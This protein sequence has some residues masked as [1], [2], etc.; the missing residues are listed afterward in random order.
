MAEGKPR[1]HLDESV[2]PALARALRRHGIDVTTT[3]EVG[4]RTAADAEQ[5]AF[6]H[7]TGR[8]LITHDTDFLRS[9]KQETAHPGIVF[10]RHG[11]LSIGAMAEELILLWEI[12][13][14]EELR[15]R[16]ELF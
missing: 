1:F 2:D 3:V 12:F 13:R 9:A 16:V 6:A 15:G 4:L 5:L 8:V 14:A 10:I 11:K 7:A